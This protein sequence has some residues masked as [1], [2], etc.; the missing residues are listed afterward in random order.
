[1]SI[2]DRIRELFGGKQS[3]VGA[4][5]AG[6]A[7]AA[8]AGDDERS[9]VELHR[10]GLVGRRRLRRRQRR[11]RRQQRRQLA[12]QL[13]HAQRLAERRDDVDA[14]GA[15][16]AP[17]RSARARA[18]CR[19]RPR[20]APASRERAPGAARGTTMPGHLVV[21]RAARAG[22]SCSGKTPTSSGIGDVAAEPL[23][24]A[25][26]A[27]RGRTGSASSRSARP[28]RASRRSAR[29]RRVEVVRGRVDGDA[30]EERR[31]RVDR[32]GRCSPRRG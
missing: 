27:A 6:G 21:Q 24:E 5:T 20:P 9:G 14:R 12:E 32:R 3:A 31:R 8:T 19:P 17:P 30:D 2:I 23:A 13:E 28:P 26:R 15:S 7:A 25:G 1:M 4:T 16:R 29:A 22:S 18:P 10:L 11:R